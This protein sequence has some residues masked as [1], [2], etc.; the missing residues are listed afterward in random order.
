VVSVA[1]GAPITTVTIVRNQNFLAL[2]EDGMY[3]YGQHIASAANN[4][5]EQGF[6]DYNPGGGTIR[7]IP[8]T[9]INGAQALHG[10]VTTSAGSVPTSK[11]ITDFQRTTLAGRSALVGTFTPTETASTTTN[12]VTTVTDTTVGWALTEVGADP[13]VSTINIADGA[14]VSWDARRQ[15]EDRRRVFVYQ[16]GLYNGFHMGVNGIPNLQQACYVG[17]N[18]GLADSWTRQGGR[19]GCSMRFYTLTVTDSGAPPTSTFT[20]MSSSSSDIPNPTAVLQDYPGRWPQ[21]QNPDFTDGRPYSLVDFEIRLAGS[22]P[23]DPICPD[24]DKLTVWDT[25]HGTRKSVLDPPIPPIV[26][27]RLAAD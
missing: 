21:S 22:A 20:G 23:S 7:F 13:L 24:R 14:W 4:G 18:L 15:V 17:N 10:A 1:G 5:V 9:D 8:F 2:F 16:H 6:Y 25:Q 12:G 27:C 3:L 19:S 11:T 26:L